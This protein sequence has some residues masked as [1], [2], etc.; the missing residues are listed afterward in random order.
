MKRFFAFLCVA[1]VL[2]ATSALAEPIE[3]PA[4]SYTA[5][6]F[7][8]YTGYGTGGATTRYSYAQKVDRNT[9]KSVMIQ[10]YS[11]GTTTAASFTGTFTLQCSPDN[12]T[13]WITAKDVGGNA[14]SATTGPLVYD[15]MTRC[16]MVRASYLKSSAGAPNISVWLLYG[17]Q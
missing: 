7:T 3:N 14:I 17:D 8:N 11:T 4:G 12:G 1:A 10:G 5:A 6:L 9:V 13:T 16:P 15:L 2:C